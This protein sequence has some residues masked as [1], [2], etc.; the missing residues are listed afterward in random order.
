M[1]QIFKEI[2]LQGQTIKK[3]FYHND[4]LFIVF[5][6]DCFCVMKANPYSEPPSV[7][8]STELISVKL[9]VYNAKLLLQ[10][11]LADMSDVERLTE[12][13]IESNAKLVRE[14][15]LKQLKALKEKYPDA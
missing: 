4:K 10:L 5:E 15:E 3:T 12:E 11:G 7:E 13:Y 8:L 1:T 9:D 2:E 6:D 14:N